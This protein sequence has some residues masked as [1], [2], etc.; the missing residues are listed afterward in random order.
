MLTKLTV[1]AFDHYIC[2]HSSP[3][4]HDYQD[5]LKKS[6]LT[7]EHPLCIRDTT[8]LSPVFCMRQRY[9][10]DEVAQGPDRVGESGQ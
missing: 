4:A 8:Q 7:Q 5:H 6:I 2:P 10:R 1:L 9:N 3:E